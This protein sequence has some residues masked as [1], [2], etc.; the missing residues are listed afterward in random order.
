LANQL[1]K[2]K[3]QLAEDTAAS[4]QKCRVCNSPVA[5]NSREGLCWV[6]RRLKIS[7]WAD[8]DNQAP[9]QE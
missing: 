5:T 4:K 8:A 9:L 7:A 6:C 2:N 3:K 1:A